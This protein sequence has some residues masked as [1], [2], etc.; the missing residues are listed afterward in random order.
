MTTVPRPICMGCSLLLTEFKCKAYP[1]GI[2]RPIL[3]S[4]QDH[5]TSQPGDGGLTFQP[6]TDADAAYAARLFGAPKNAV[7]SKAG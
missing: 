2:P 7:A 6:K 5:R 1:Q 4:E 3:L